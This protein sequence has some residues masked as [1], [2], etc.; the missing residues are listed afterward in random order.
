M[1]RAWPLLVVLALP[2]CYLSHGR[3]T[4]DGGGASDAGPGRADAGPPVRRD[5]GPPRACPISVGWCRPIHDAPVALFDE[6]SQSPDLVWGPDR[7]LFAFWAPD[8]GPR[9]FHL[10]LE[11]VILE[12]IAIGRGFNQIRVTWDP[13][14]AMGLYSLESGLFWL[15]PDGRL[16]GREWLS[17]DPRFRSLSYDVGVIDEG[18][19]VAAARRGAP[20][21]L[22]IARGEELAWSE[23]PAAVEAVISDGWSEAPLVLAGPRLHRVEGDE[24]VEVATLDVD[25]TAQPIDVLQRRGLIYTLHRL[26]G[27]DTLRRWRPDGELVAEQ[28]IGAPTGSGSTRLGLLSGQL[29]VVSTQLEPDAPIVGR[30][31]DE[32]SLAL[33]PEVLRAVD[34]VP[35]RFNRHSIAMAE[36][37]RGLAVAWT[38]GEVGSGNMRP[39]LRMYEC[40]ISE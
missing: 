19:V 5:A 37:P 4:A 33:G 15:G 29:F 21:L 6:Q 11:G 1:L 23:A 40:C 24:W 22:G 7:L 9:L 16:G 31:V 8:S 28:A 20:T 18:F 10:D 2:G 14:A 34:G 32:S 13:D 27:V 36:T 30:V 17:P 25:P 12:R 35:G 38:E 3:S 39:L 26:A